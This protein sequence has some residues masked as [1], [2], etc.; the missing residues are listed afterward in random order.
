MSKTKQ[1]IEGKQVDFELS[2]NSYGKSRVRISKIIRDGARHE[3]KEM[4]VSVKLRGDFSDTYSTGCNA[5]VVATDSIKNTVYAIAAEHPL[6]DIE[7]FALTLAKHFLS[8]EQVDAAEIDITEDFWKRISHNG[9]EHEHSF[10][11]GGD[12]KRLTRIVHDRKG[13]TIESGITELYVL[14]TTAS[15]FFGFVRDKYTT[16]A[17]VNDRIFATAIE[18]RWFFDEAKEEQ[19]RDY[20]NIF[21]SNKKT[22]LEVFASHHSLSVQQTLYVMAEELLRLH[23]T[24]AEVKITMPNRHRIPFNVEPFGLKN[25]NEIFVTTDEP[26]GLIEGVVRRKV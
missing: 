24:I 17:D 7:S 4:A 1:D 12:E 20:N 13:T 19:P 18:A 3:I 10:V 25:Q 26:Y 23:H 6:G 22:L 11:K 2:A 5:K 16:L 14:K 21:E 15:E 8:Y 9:K